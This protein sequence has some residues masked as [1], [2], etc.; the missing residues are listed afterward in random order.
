MPPGKALELGSAHGAF[1]A[2]LRWS[3][4]D[5]VGLELS[6]WLVN[7]AKNMFDVPMLTGPIEDQKLAPRSLDVIALMDVLEHLPSPLATMERC[8]RLLKEDGVLV[9]QTPRYP[10]TRSYEEMVAHTDPFLEQLRCAIALPLRPVGAE[11]GDSGVTHAAF[12]RRFLPI[13]TCSWSPPQRPCR[14]L[15]VNKLKSS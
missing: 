3:R 1:V 2:L 6:P 10:Q 9:I 14:L 11:Y 15:P 4:F 7:F 5:A 8:L 13:T 12:E